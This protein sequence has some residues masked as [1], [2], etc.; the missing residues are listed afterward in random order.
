MKR[1]PSQDALMDMIRFFFFF[2]YFLLVCPP[3]EESGTLSDQKV[4]TANRDQRRT[5]PLASVICPK[6][7]PVCVSM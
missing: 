1:V 6:F 7:L 4:L 5:I 3:M 2:F